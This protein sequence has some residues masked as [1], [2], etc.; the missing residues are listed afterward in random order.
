MQEL[1]EV[2][3]K[4]ESS[5]QTVKTVGFK[6]AANQANG[7]NNIKVMD[8]YVRVGNLV[9][10]DGPRSS[11]TALRHRNT[12]EREDKSFSF[13]LSSVESQQRK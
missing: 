3:D 4:G 11:R 5:E 6:I 10:M 12:A 9:E 13:S 1:K 7:R 8:S 2:A